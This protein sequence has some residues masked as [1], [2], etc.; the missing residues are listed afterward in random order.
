MPRFFLTVSKAPQSVKARLK[1]QLYEH[2]ADL[3]L[4][5]RWTDAGIRCFGLVAKFFGEYS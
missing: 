3:L 5:E 2:F 1:R 4:Q